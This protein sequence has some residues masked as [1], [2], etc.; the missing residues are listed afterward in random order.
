MIDG[1]L[2]NIPF[3]LIHCSSL[4]IFWRKFK[5]FEY[6]IRDTGSSQ[7]FFSDIQKKKIQYILKKFISFIAFLLSFFC[8]IFY[9]FQCAIFSNKFAILHNFYFSEM[10]RNRKKKNWKYRFNSIWKVTSVA[11]NTSKKVLRSYT[12]KC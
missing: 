6:N 5:R 1:R 9:P 8:C 4:I 11:D 2:A 7:M 3:E 10:N 12:W